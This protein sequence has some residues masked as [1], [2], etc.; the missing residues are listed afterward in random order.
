MDTP[1]STNLDNPRLRINDR[2][3]I[4]GHAIFPNTEIK[5]IIDYLIPKTGL[6]YKHIEA[7][8]ISK[9]FWGE[10]SEPESY[11]GPLGDCNGEND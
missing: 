9:D 11:R 8:R 7:S 6:K 4:T 10:I 5:Y 1:T 2:R 3:W